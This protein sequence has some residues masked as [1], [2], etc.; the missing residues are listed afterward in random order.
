MLIEKLLSSHL[1]TN[2]ASLKHKYLTYL[3]FGKI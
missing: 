3:T 1:E 2:L